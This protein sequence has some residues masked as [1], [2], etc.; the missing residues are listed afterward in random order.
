MEKIV[1]KFGNS[2]YV[3]LP[4]GWVGKTVII[5]INIKPITW[6]AIDQRIKEIIEEYKRY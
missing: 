5:E 2:G 4:K 6:A 1:K 3:T